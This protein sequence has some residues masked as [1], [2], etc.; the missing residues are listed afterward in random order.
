VGAGAHGDLLEQIG[1]GI[2]LARIR[3]QVDYIP[4]QSAGARSG[5][6]Q[7]NHS[8]TIFGDPGALPTRPMPE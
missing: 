6:G 3:V 1:R 8:A 5:Y 7:T 2:I 4:H